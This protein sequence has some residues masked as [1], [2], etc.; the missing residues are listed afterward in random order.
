MSLAPLLGCSDSNDNKVLENKDIRGNDPK[1]LNECRKVTDNN[2]IYKTAAK[3]SIS[4]PSSMRNLS[5]ENS[6]NSDCELKYMKFHF[7]WTGEKLI[8]IPKIG[9][10]ELKDFKIEIGVKENE[11]LYLSEGYERLTLM[12]YFKDPAEGYSAYEKYHCK[13]KS[14]VYEYPEYNVIMCPYLMGAKKS[15]N[16]TTLPFFPRFELVD[17]RPY[18]TSFECEHKYFDG[19]TVENIHEI[20]VKY[21]CRGSWTWRPGAGG[22]FDIHQGKVIHKAYNVMRAAETILDSWITEET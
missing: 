7:V 11:A 8:F 19:Y 22:M 21:S 4:V 12:L 14:P 5:L 9:S 6:Y 3:F 17:E 15:P 1:A 13:N 16:I 2:I 20:D 18:V 10:K